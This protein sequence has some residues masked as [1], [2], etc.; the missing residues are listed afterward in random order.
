MPASM[1]PHITKKLVLTAFI[2]LAAAMAI[3]AAPINFNE[4]SLWVRARETD[5][6][7]VRE[8]GRRKLAHPLTP[9]QEATLKTQG[10]SESLLRS[11]RSPNLV[12]PASEAPPAETRPAPA[13]G[14]ARV[15]PPEENE[16]V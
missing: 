10:A 9:Q 7:I 1:K 16:N 8:I 11:L 2:I 15:S 4:I 12:A 6:S 5:Q 13:P 14:P 3:T